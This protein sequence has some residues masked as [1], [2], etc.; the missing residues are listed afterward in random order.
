MSQRSRALDIEITR[1]KSEIIEDFMEYRNK[2]VE[3]D[4]DF[5]ASYKANIYGTGNL[6]E[7]AFYEAFA[8]SSMKMTVTPGTG[9]ETMESMAKSVMSVE[10]A[11]VNLRAKVDGIQ[12]HASTI[13]TGIDALEDAGFDP[14][15]E[16]RKEQSYG[17][18]AAE[19]IE[20][21]QEEGVPLNV[22]SRTDPVNNHPD[23][24]Y[25]VANYKPVNQNLEPN[26]S[27]CAPDIGT[28]EEAEEIN[29]RMEDV[30]DEVGL[31]E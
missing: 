25:V 1:T 4:A 22:W 14:Y 18:S 27:V 28:Q 8:D 24:H 20:S 29:E 31:L 11:E 19:A 12:D 21:I 5:P 26:S 13:Q 16:I 9:F 30:L 2:K 15:A 10:D 6:A 7:D 17:G 23:S 3:S